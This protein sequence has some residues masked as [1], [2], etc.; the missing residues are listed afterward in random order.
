MSGR[1]D[2]RWLNL[3]DSVFQ[4]AVERVLVCIVTHV[5][6]GV[7]LFDGVG[8]VCMEKPVVVNFSTFLGNTANDY[9]GYT[10]GVESVVVD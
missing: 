4:N 3:Y 5:S 10:Y 6:R 7:V 2:S 1:R 9:G 8:R